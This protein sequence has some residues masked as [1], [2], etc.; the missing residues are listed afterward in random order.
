MKWDKDALY[1]GN[2]NLIKA[3]ETRIKLA[4]EDKDKRA[5][6]GYSESRHHL[7]INQ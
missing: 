3:E 6:E 5:A 1:V 2:F 4:A 7:V